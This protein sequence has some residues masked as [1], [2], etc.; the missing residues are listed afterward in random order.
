MQII[1][2]ALGIMAIFWIAFWLVQKFM[3]RRPQPSDAPNVRRTLVTGARMLGGSD[4]L[5][6]YPPI[7][8]VDEAQGAET[9]DPHAD[10]QSEPAPK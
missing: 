1:I 4:F 3:V 5:R 6:S 2:A 8:I 9:C 10:H 7:E